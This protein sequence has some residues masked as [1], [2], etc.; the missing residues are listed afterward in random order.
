VVLS[1]HASNITVLPARK[2][3][4]CRTPAFVPLMKDLD[5]ALDNGCHLDRIFGE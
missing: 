2:A 3:L 1:S 4:K 5:V